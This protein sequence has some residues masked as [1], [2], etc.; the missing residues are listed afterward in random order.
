MK[1]YVNYLLKK[2]LYACICLLTTNELYSSDNAN[3]PFD[4]I[5]KCTNNFDKQDLL[6]N[7]VYNILQD[8][9][10]LVNIAKH[11]IR[12]GHAIPIENIVQIKSNKLLPKFLPIDMRSDLFD[13]VKQ[14]YSITY[15]SKENNTGEV[16][17]LKN[18]LVL[19]RI[20]KNGNIC[21]SEKLV[22]FIMLSNRFQ[23]LERGKKIDE[24]CKLDMKEFSSVL[25]VFPRICEFT[26]GTLRNFDPVIESLK[27]VME[28]EV[29]KDFN[30]AAL[31]VQ[32]SVVCVLIDL[33]KITDRLNSKN[34]GY[35]PDRIKTGSKNINVQIGG[36]EK[37][38]NKISKLFANYLRIPNINALL[39]SI[40]NLSKSG[41]IDEILELRHKI[42][43]L[44]ESRVIKLMQSFTQKVQDV[45]NFVM[46][47]LKKSAKSI[48]ND[49]SI[50]I[51]NKNSLS[52]SNISNNNIDTKLESKEGIP[53]LVVTRV[54][55][56]KEEEEFKKYINACIQQQNSN[57]SGYDIQANNPLDNV[58]VK[59]VISQEENVSFL[60]T[61]YIPLD[62]AK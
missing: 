14:F 54:Y 58:T 52:D 43:D 49:I 56:S 29:M 33:L 37:I 3:A 59:L 38:V 16:Q 55:S 22:D 46:T 53:Q 20:D 21:L 47:D 26:T 40:T 7:K 23:G 30:G 35:I 9:N 42:E 11:I 17:K 8:E 45:D 44:F 61:F 36:N 34:S 19:Q 62:S 6:W 1:M 27:N 39:N 48:F 13:F 41:S 15:N 31:S 5:T 32:C 18:F 4:D 50:F 28:M 10:K 25:S 2:I 24:L 60:S 51:N 57:T 12:R